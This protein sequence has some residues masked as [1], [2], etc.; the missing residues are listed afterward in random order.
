MPERLANQ[1]LEHQSKYA[2][3]S[4]WIP[5]EERYKRLI[6][7]GLIT[8]WNYDNEAVREP[9]IEHVGHLPIIAVFL[10]QHIE[11]CEE[12]NLG[13]VLIMLAI[14]DI[15]ETE[16][17]DVL[18]YNKT[19][20]VEESEL[21]AAKRLLPPSLFGLFSEFE[22]RETVDAKFAKAVDSIAPILREIT[23]PPEVISGRF[24]YY[25]FNKD[26]I[27][28]KKRPHFEWDKVLLEMFVDLMDKYPQIEK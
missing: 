1:L 21:A 23:L 7:S 25:N 9:L 22:E 6:Q 27:V 17:G 28:N 24:E 11:H 14:H 19:S 10:H 16:V 2:S 15:G 20:K 18:T 3:V 8:E 4:R 5:T 13:R 26:M 12:V